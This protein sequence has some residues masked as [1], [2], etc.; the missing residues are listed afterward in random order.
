M[1]KILSPH[2]FPSFLHAATPSSLSEVVHAIIYWVDTA[3]QVLYGH[4][5]YIITSLHA[6]TY[7]GEPLPHTSSRRKPEPIVNCL[8]VSS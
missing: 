6:T 4:C 3:C 7:E 5:I 2:T 1:V 8:K